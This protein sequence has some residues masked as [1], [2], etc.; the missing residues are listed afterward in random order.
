M[1]RRNRSP[2]TC[3]NHRIPILCLDGN[4]FLPGLRATHM[5]CRP[6]ATPRDPEGERK[7]CTRA[8]KNLH[9]PT[10]LHEANLLSFPPFKQRLPFPFLSFLRRLTHAKG[11]KNA[12]DDGS[13]KNARVIL[14]L[15]AE[16]RVSVSVQDASTRTHH[17]DVVDLKRSGRLRTWILAFSRRK[18][19]GVRVR[20][21][22]TEA[23]FSCPGDRDSDAQCMMMVTQ[24]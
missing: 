11:D 7:R 10:D 15:Q 17:Q 14:T 13:R 4:C 20:D 3:I 2:E 19:E 22:W 12:N 21:T 6:A 8:E 24:S 1:R 18:R 9:D 5:H 23:D 16:G